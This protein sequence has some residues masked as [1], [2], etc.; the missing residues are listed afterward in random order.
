MTEPYLQLEHIAHRYTE[1]DWCL[2]DI[3]IAMNPGEFIGIIGPNGAGKSTLLKIAA[4]TLSP[5]NGSVT[6]LGKN[7]HT[8][9]RRAIAREMAYLPQGVTSLF[10]YRVEEL[11]AMGRFPHL[12]AAGFMR[13]VDIEIVEKCMTLTDTTAFRH[14]QVSHLSGGEKQRVLLASVLAQ[15]PRVLLLD[16]PTTGLDI[17]HQIAFFKRLKDLAAKGIAVAT[18]TH[19][20]NL[21]GQFCDTLFLMANGREVTTGQ[22]QDVLKQDILAEVYQENI[23]VGRHPKTGKP[24]V[25]PDN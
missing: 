4:G 23:Y 12:P 15:E 22:V 3:H 24:I 8:L 11:I 13:P 2:A 9:A 10:D 7:I 17:H 18:V 5:Q 19:D 6:L 20:L 16:E 21:A 1:A 14:R 25:L